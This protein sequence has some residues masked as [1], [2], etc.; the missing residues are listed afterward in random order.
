[1]SVHKLKK[2]KILTF[3]FNSTRGK[4]KFRSATIVTI[5]RGANNRQNNGHRR[6][7]FFEVETMW[8]GLAAAG[9]VG[10]WPWGRGP[11]AC[12]GRDRGGAGGGVLLKSRLGPAQRPESARNL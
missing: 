10:A 12:Q 5:A 11:G 1:M 7:V 9:W 8:A 2:K 3:L 6:L 4:K